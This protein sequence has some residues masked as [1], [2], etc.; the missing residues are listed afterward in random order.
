MWI[1]NPFLLGGGAPLVLIGA[2]LAACRFAG[3]AFAAG[4]SGAI[5]PLEGSASTAANLA[6]SL[7]CSERKFLRDFRDD[8]NLDEQRKQK[9][10][11]EKIVNDAVIEQIDSIENCC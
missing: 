6:I 5:S 3:G 7:A 2:G 8:R 10:V 1:T 9:L 4:T 11:R